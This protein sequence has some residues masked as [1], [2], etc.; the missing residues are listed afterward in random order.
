MK[1][2]IADLGR[3][4]FA[5][6][7]FSSAS[8]WKD[9]YSAGGNSGPGSYGELAKFK[10]DVLNR[11]VREHAVGSV[12]EFGCGDGNQLGLAHYPAYTGIDVSPLAVESC[13]ERFKADASKEFL[14][15][16]DDDGRQADLALSLD[17]VF[18]LTE[19]RVFDA[20]MRRLFEAGRRYVIVYS[21]D[22]DEPVQPA[23][24]HVRHRH[25]SQWVEREMGARWTLVERIPNAFPYNG[26]YR[27]TSFCDF[28]I[29][30]RSGQA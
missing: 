25:F 12:I 9:R 1:T 26:D 29:Y 7:N 20:Y 24:P 6:S 13:R 5:R 30:R 28:F 27:T 3:K 4:W 10:A 22:R 21:S 8:Y 23:A 19:D 2:W 17:V 18:H 14:L 15:A 11:F 16:P